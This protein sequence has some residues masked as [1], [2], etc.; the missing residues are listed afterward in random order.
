MRTVTIE[1]DY[2]RQ[3]MLE[4]K[5]STPKLQ[6]WNRLYDFC[7]DCTNTLADRLLGRGEQVPDSHGGIF[8]RK[9]TDEVQRQRAIA[10]WSPDQRFSQIICQNPTATIGKSDVVAMTSDNMSCDLV[11]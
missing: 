5:A 7:Q 10:S 4:S 8:N 9:I 6:I 3:P 11:R 1:C 2:C